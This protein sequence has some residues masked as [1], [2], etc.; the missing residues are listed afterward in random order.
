MINA[1]K[2]RYTNK[3]QYK[4]LQ[5]IAQYNTILQNNFFY[6]NVD[7]YHDISSNTFTYLSLILDDLITLQIYGPNQ[8]H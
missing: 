8:F 1:V 5:N 4:A 7:I 3:K 6:V 2:I